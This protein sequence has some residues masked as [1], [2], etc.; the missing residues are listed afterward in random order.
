MTSTLVPSG[1][2][3]PQA[4]STSTLGPGNKGGDQGGGKSTEKEGEANPVGNHVLISVGSI[5]K[6]RLF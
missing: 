6:Y 4:D 3:A 5:G 1:T 2:V